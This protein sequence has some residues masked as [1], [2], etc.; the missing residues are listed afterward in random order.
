MSNEVA[1]L[2]RE[3]RELRSKLET[4]QTAGAGYYHSPMEVTEF[5]AH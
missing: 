5:F 3:I 1:A 2:Q 4:A